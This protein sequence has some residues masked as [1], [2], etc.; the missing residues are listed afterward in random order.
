MNIVAIAERWARV[1]RSSAWGLLQKMAT[2]TA[3]FTLATCRRTPASPTQARY[4]SR[5]IHARTSRSRNRCAANCVRTWSA[6][7]SSGCRPTG[8]ICDAHFPRTLPRGSK[9]TSCCCSIDVG[10][11]C[12]LN[13][14]RATSW[15][16]TSACR[17][18]SA[19]TGGKAKGRAGRI[20][21]PVESLLLIG[22]R[23]SPSTTSCSTSSGVLVKFN[24]PRRFGSMDVISRD[25]LFAK[26]SLQPANVNVGRSSRRVARCFAAAPLR[27]RT[28]PVRP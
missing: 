24:D 1:N 4:R 17:D 8:P 22:R 15:S 2:K 21:G 9:G 13:C 20:A 26:A 5:L 6:R 23:R 7:A 18:R 27:A 12:W 16:C 25:D 10:N 3:G 28:R 14:R 11:I 19:S